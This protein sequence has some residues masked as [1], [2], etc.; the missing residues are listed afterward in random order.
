MRIN[1]APVPVTGITCVGTLPVYRGK[2]HI[3]QVIAR[4][5]KMLY[6]K[7]EQPIA[8]LYAARAASMST[9]REC[10]AP[11]IKSCIRNTGHSAPIYSKHMRRFL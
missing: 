3:G 7:G 5:F 8:V 1:G 4:H 2:D 9:T 6:E 11:G 10:C